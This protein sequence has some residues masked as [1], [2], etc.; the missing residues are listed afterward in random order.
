LQLLS[1]S[2]SS[3]SWS[4][5]QTNTLNRASDHVAGLRKLFNNNNST[6]STSNSSSSGSNVILTEAE[7][8]DL[9]KYTIDWTKVYRGGTVVALPR[10]TQEVSA[11]MTYCH[12]HRIG[13]VPQGTVCKCK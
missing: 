6:S 3:S 2:S 1:T 10:S 4:T 8:G 5:T 13:V 11:I 7:D 12:E 9:S